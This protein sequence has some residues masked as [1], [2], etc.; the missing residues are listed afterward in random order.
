MTLGAALKAGFSLARCA[1]AGVWVLFL[2]NF[3]LAA[4]AALPIY[5]GILFF[6][7]YSLVSRELL[8]G[9]RIEWLTD[10]S[11]NSVGS[12]DRYAAFIAL[13]GLISIPVNTVLAGGVVSRFREPEASFSLGGFFRDTGR[14]FWRLIRLM[15]IG[16]VCYWLVFRVF[17]QWLGQWVAERTYDWPDDRSVFAARAAVWLLLLGGLGFVNLVMDY[18][19]V[20]LVL[21]DGTSA[22][23]AFLSSLGFSLSRLR[24]TATIYVVPMLASLALL[25]IYWLIVPWSVI[26]AP[27]ADV[28]L[29]RYQEPLVAALLLIGQ[30]LVMFGR[31]WFRVAGWASAWS[32][33]SG[34]RQI[35]S[36]T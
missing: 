3:G 4:I 21:E 22:A 20:K 9:F 13:I 27:A 23:G 32:Y 5:R 8:T 35:S 29:A 25:G 18:A 12:L 19:R 14:Y 7:G 2:V 1:R 31:Y 10:F 26:Q 30:Q 11:F 34:S 24:R 15:I 36:Q 33:Y 6:T 17:N 28:G 16:L